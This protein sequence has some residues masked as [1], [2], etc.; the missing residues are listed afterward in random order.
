VSEPLTDEELIRHAGVMI[1]MD[2][3]HTLAGFDADGGKH[4]PGPQT[5]D[6]A[7][8]YLAQSLA[9][10][11]ALTAERTEC[12]L[13]PD[14]SFT[15]AGDGRW[16]CDQCAGNDRYRARALAAEAERDRYRDALEQVCDHGDRAAVMIAL[17][18]LA[19]LTEYSTPDT[20]EN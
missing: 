10:I 8:R 17:A 3:H 1:A 7:K 2:L 5:R 18:A 13:H 11:A 20:E 12:L 14:G 6:M 15:G 4:E 9:T 16:Q 19:A